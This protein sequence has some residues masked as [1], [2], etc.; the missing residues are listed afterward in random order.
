MQPTPPAI[1]SIRLPFSPSK[2]ERPDRVN[3]GMCDRRCRNAPPLPPCPP[4]KNSGNGCQQNITP[5]EVSGTLV[6]MGKPK[7]HCRDHQRPASS[8]APFQKILHPRAKIKF[9]RDCNKNKDINPRP[10][11][12]QMKRSAMRMQKSQRQSCSQNE[13]RKEK[14][15][16]QSRLPIAPMKMKI[17]SR[18]AQPLDRAESVQP[19]IYQQQLAEAAQPARPRAFQ[20]AE[21]NRQ[22][23]RQQNNRVS[24]IASLLRIRRRGLTQQ[25]RYRHW[26][27][28][29]KRTPP[30]QKHL[31]RRGNQNVRYNEDYR[32]K[33]S[34]SRG[35]AS[36]HLGNSLAA[37]SES[38]CRRQLQHKHC[39]RRRSDVLH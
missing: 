36:T 11:H 25:P 13:R 32:Q 21:I 8:D 27:H 3:A 12:R 31:M 14:Q 2:P 16:P 24:P 7:Q 19:C 38:D 33:S 23:Q 15:F 5:V 1:F 34:Q 37:D 17:K 35:P 10:D 6:E 22:P 39:N 30:P 28:G 29:V 20:P 18:P 4:I 9:L 26:Q